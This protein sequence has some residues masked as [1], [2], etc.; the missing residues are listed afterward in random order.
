MCQRQE[1]HSTTQKRGLCP[2]SAPGVGKGR[3][4]RINT[5]ILQNIE[6]SNTA[7]WCAVC[8]DQLVVERIDTVLTNTVHLIQ[9]GN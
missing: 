5:N 3:E 7:F 2:S 4:R 1:A 6:C 8:T 9:Q